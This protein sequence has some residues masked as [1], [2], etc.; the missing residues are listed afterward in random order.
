MRR[1]PYLATLP[2]WY[3]AAE[4]VLETRRADARV[5][6]R[7]ERLIVQLRA[8]VTRVNICDHLTCVLLRAQESSGEFVQTDPFGTGQLDRAVQ[9]RREGE[10]G[11][12]SGNVIRYDGLHKGRRQANR[13]PI[14]GRLDD[15]VEE[16]EELC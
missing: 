4:P 15:A 7:G 6:A 9:R 12:C 2:L 10:V 11:Q 14:G 3:G 13:L 16:L 1:R 8:E 5:L